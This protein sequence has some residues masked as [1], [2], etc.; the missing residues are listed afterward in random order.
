MNQKTRFLIVFILISLASLLGQ[1]GG[2]NQMDRLLE[3]EEPIGIRLSLRRKEE[4]GVR[5]ELIGQAVLLPREKAMVVY[6]VNTDAYYRIESGEK[7]S[8]VF[9]MKPGKADRF[10][11]FTGVPSRYHLDFDAEELSRL[12]DI[13]GGFE[14]YLEH[15]LVLDQALFQYPRGVLYMPGKQLVEYLTGK[16]QE[17][18]PT[19]AHLG[20]VDRLYRAESV[21][22][23][24]IWNLPEMTEKISSPEIREAMI[25]LPDTNLKREEI[26]SILEF[27]KKKETIACTIEVPLEELP[28]PGAVQSYEKALVVKSS[29]A[30]EVY[31]KVLSNIQ[32]KGY[33]QGAY[34][35]DVLNGT[36]KGGLAKRVKQ[37]IQNE[38]L[39]VL[40]VDNFPY[41]PVKRTIV[42]DRS[43]NTAYPARLSRLTG[44]DRS[45]VYFSRSLLDVESTLVI[46]TDFNFR[47]IKLDE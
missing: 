47:N 24:V 29:R 32:N 1:C 46:G 15:D 37:Y 3:E 21:L 43:G 19:R 28:L 40:D 38:H 8:P 31:E 11:E 9:S 22:L 30:P 4:E 6:S 36:E 39:Q 10:E 23:S 5:L 44:L 26:Q 42:L 35:V 18:D 7:N 41:K 17:T 45:R 34:H 2:G 12:V 13:S 33:R 20:G 27:L 16:K 14:V 25:K